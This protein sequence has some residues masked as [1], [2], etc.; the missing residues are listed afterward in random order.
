MHLGKQELEPSASWIEVRAHLWTGPQAGRILVP[1][2]AALQARA[3]L[4]VF[5][6]MWIL[7]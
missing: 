6:G 5:S 2:G 7:A 3:V 1:S 4:T